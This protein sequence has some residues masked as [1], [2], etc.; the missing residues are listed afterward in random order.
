M[1]LQAFQQAL[2][3]LVMSPE[4]RQRLQEEPEAA[5]A[6]YDLDPRERRRVLSVAADQR[7]RAST[8]IHRSFRLGML[9]DTMPRT[10]AALGNAGLKE[11]V[12][13]YWRSH[14][15]KDYYYAREAARFGAY[16]LEQLA[17]GEVVSPYAEEVL[18]FELAS[19]E[20]RRSASDEAGTPAEE[21]TPAERRV[22]FRH[23]PRVLLPALDRKEIPAAV[24]EGTFE[25]RIRRLPSGELVTELV[26]EGAGV[27]SLTPED[28]G[29]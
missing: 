3:E 29:R 22:T 12:H 21:P 20:L 16:L 11:I 18:H 15:P 9:L 2:S 6:A 27:G 26:G 4:F 10:C 8:V 14:L 24:P 13:A 1:S 23:D 28:D 17:G 5:L 7:V 19:L 25:V